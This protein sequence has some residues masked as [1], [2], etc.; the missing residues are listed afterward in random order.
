MSLPAYQ[1]HTGRPMIFDAQHVRCWRRL[2]A[3]MKL[4]KQSWVMFSRESS[5]SITGISM[6]ENGA[7]GSQGCLIVWKKLLRHIRRRSS[8][9]AIDVPVFGVW[10]IWIPANGRCGTS[11]SGMQHGSAAPHGFE[12]GIEPA[13][14]CRA[15]VDLSMLHVI[16]DGFRSH[17][18]Y[19]RLSTGR[20]G[21]WFAKHD[22]RRELLLFGYADRMHSRRG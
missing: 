12:I 18:F 4:P 9:D 13:V 5:A 11:A 3:R 7:S 17:N 2:V 15:T 10:C 19:N 14:P 20:A 22:E 21:G 8:V 16:H 6:T 1:S